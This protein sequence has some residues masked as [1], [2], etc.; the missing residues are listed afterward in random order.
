MPKSPNKEDKKHST[1]KANPNHQ[2]LK[3]QPPGHHAYRVVVAASCGLCGS[4]LALGCFRLAGL[5]ASSEL[6]LFRP[7]PNFSVAFS[8]VFSMRLSGLGAPKSGL[9]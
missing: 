6:E 2:M 5:E 4:R 3:E 8:M 9:Y 7:P 1:K